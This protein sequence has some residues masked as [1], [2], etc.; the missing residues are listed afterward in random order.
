MVSIRFRF[1]AGGKAVTR[2]ATYYAKGKDTLPVV[3]LVHGQGGSD[4]DWSDPR[5][6]GLH[7]D[8][9]GAA[10]GD[11]DY[12]WHLLPPVGLPSHGAVLDGFRKNVSG[13]VP[14]LQDRG[15]RVV[16]YAQRDSTGP[17][18]D[19]AVEL[20]ALVEALIAHLGQA[21]TQRI[22]LLA[23]SRGGLVVRKYLKDDAGS[24]AVE[25][26]SKVVTLHS[27][28]QGSQL[29]NLSIAAGVALDVLV[30]GMNPVP[31][32][33]N[34]IRDVF[35]PLARGLNGTSRQDLAI[36]SQFLTRLASGERA[37]PGV[38]YYTFGGTSCTLARVWQYVYSS[39]SWIP[40]QHLPP[41]RH[42]AEAAQWPILSP[43][44]ETL[45]APCDEL[46]HRRGDGLVTDA[47]SRLPF[48]FHRTNHVNHAEAL[49]DT[50]VKRQ[51]ADVLD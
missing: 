43:I 47:R 12:G 30:A 22:A 17:I 4:K 23:H 18:A 45:I 32:L 14:Y 8:Y 40:R 1:S 26:I 29:A 21:S 37:L 49:W 24:K 5:T 36:G 41:F 35:R 28:H 31:V 10:P 11:I 33:G 39:S 44:G 13:F 27:P 19:S 2:T 50:Q 38:A 16:N 7:Y 46:R 25:R 9:E 6:Y 42:R 34:V 20:E 51:V 15:F 48:A 3:V